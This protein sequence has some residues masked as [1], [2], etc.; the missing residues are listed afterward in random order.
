LFVEIFNY[1]AI[2]N[3]FDPG[4]NDSDD[5]GADELEESDAL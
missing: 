4:L 5:A 1:F 3:D 2:F